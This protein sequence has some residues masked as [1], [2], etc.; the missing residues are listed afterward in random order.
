MRYRVC[1]N[2]SLRAR[3]GYRALKDINI[4][5]LPEGVLLQGACD[6]GKTTKRRFAEVSVVD[7]KQIRKYT[8]LDGVFRPPPWAYRLSDFP[9]Q[10]GQFLSR[11]PRSCNRE[12]LMH[13]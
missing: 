2:S 10:E 4:F 3:S 12:T 13:A 9:E 1:I 7:G 11:P 8:E 5:S 6:C